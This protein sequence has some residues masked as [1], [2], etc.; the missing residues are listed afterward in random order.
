M[1]ASSGIGRSIGLS[2]GATGAR[3]ALAAR[4]LDLVEEVARTV[5]DGGGSSRAWRCDVTVEDECHRLVDES[6]EWLGGLDMVF[7]MAGSSPLVRI[8]DAT[9]QDWRSLV[10]TNLVGAA[11][12]IARSLRHLRRS[13]DPVVVVTSHSMGQ[14]WPWLGCYGAVKAG[15]AEL[16]RSL[17]AEEPW[18]RSV[19]VS[20]GNTATSF[21][22][23]WDAE[24]FA[25]AMDLWVAEGRM[26]HSVLT[27]DEMASAIL[28]AASSGGPDELVVRGDDVAP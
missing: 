20:V 24:V 15:L 13:P 27:A 5:R 22:D 4:R 12:V 3:V 19:C 25:R 11:L 17:R 16:A 18:L 26:R 10:D 23:G 2:L 6:A 7:Y 21:A 28:D 8:E 9:A 1:G 14:P